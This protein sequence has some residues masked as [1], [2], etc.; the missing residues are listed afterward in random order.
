[1]VMIKH[2][3]VAIAAFGLAV[4]PAMAQTRSASSLPSRSV[5]VE[6]STGQCVEIR[7]DSPS[8]APTSVPVDQALCDQAAGPKGV[9]GAA[10][11]IAKTG[12]L[13]LSPAL[14]LALLAVVGAVAAAAGG[15][16]NDSPG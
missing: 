3:L 14:L 7:R 4:T 1:M 11:A 8:S 16:H 10:S 9:G 2:S 12:G 5:M 6:P 15:G 13:G